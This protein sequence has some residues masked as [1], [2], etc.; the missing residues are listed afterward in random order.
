MLSGPVYTIVRRGWSVAAITFAFLVIVLAGEARAGDN[1][2]EVWADHQE[3]TLQQQ[4]V[5]IQG[6][7]N[8]AQAALEEARRAL[9][10]AKE[11]DDKEAAAIAEEAITIAS[12]ALGRTKAK[13]QRVQARM[14]AVEK[15]RIWGSEAKGVRNQVG[16][17]SVIRGDV[18]MKTAQAWQSLD[19]SVPLKAGD[20][21]RTGGDGFAELVFTD[22]STVVLDADSGFKVA[23]LGETDTIFDK[24]EGRLLLN[25]TCLKRIL[26]GRDC[27][28]LRILRSGASLAVRGTTFQVEA[29]PD[30]AT[31]V[32][33]MSGVV[34]ITPNQGGE[35]T[36]ITYGHKAVISKKG[37]IKELVALGLPSVD[38]WW[39]ETL[40]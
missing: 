26:K 33:V 32:T 36:Q 13:R 19:G 20:E 23:E 2:L 30:G 12:E 14:A 8:K 40:Q 10:L 17:A 5:D 9:E 15:V 3:A 7:L 21:V 38:R 39:E 28:H 1:H 37:H 24:I 4:E 22:G 16:V 6:S 29:R 31:V 27:R 34:E 25:Y 35:T 11:L 18:Q